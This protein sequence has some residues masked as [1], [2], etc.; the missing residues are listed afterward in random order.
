MCIFC[1]IINKEIPAEIIY[2]DEKTLVFLDIEP[3]NPGHCL[4]V[5]KVHYEN[6]FDAPEEVLAHLINV[7]KKISNILKVAVLAEGINIGINN[8]EVAGQVVPHLHIHI[9]P[10]YANDGFIHWHGKAYQDG[11]MQSVAEKIRKVL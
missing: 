4:V 7:A 2:E 3:N 8:G 1:K 11:E 9:I 6:I 5:P 10:R